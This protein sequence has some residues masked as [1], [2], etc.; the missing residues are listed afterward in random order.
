ML[1]NNMVGGI[2][3]SEYEYVST[4]WYKDSSVSEETQKEVSLSGA[5]LVIIMPSNVGD[6][7][8]YVDMLNGTSVPSHCHFNC[9][10]VAIPFEDGITVKFRIRYGA[11]IVYY[12]RIS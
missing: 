2:S 5:G 11:A 3:S 1:F 12:K 6:A 4:T 8:V 10:P 7:V 9:A